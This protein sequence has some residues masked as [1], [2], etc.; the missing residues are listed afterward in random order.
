MPGAKVE[1]PDGQSLGQLFGKGRRV[2]FHDRYDEAT[3]T[4]R[5]LQLAP[6]PHNDNPTLG[7]SPGFCRQ[8]GPRLGSH[9]LSPLALLAAR[10]SDGAFSTPDQVK[11]WG[12]DF[13]S[14]TRV[15]TLTSAPPTAAARLSPPAPAARLSPPATRHSDP[16]GSPS[17]EQAVTSGGHSFGPP[18]FETW[19]TN[20]S[21]HG[22]LPQPAA[23]A[24]YGAG[25]VG[26]LGPQRGGMVDLGGLNSR[27]QAQCRVEVWVMQLAGSPHE[28]ALQRRS[29]LTKGEVTLS[30]LDDIGVLQRK[31]ADLTRRP[32]HLT[33]NDVEIDGSQANRMPTAFG[34]F[35]GSRVYAYLAA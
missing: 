24:S 14:D 34:I 17:F 2:E 31:I 19:G 9:G 18:G 33:H 21:G 6:I 25:F 13:D 7:R 35:D 4:A 27:A 22:A 11:V 30:P 10:G 3:L 29:F 32:F 12:R 23:S 8:R 5:H 16:R 15:W 26:M 28:P 1:S 20:G